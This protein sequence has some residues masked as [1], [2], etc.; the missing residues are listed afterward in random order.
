MF[1][2]IDTNSLISLAASGYG[3]DLFRKMISFQKNK[4]VKLLIS[5]QL[6]HEYKRNVYSLT[7][8]NKKHK[9]ATIE[10][11][12]KNAQATYEVVKKEFGEQV[13][14]SLDSDKALKRFTEVTEKASRKIEKD[15]K[16]VQDKI[17]EMFALG[18][19]MDES[20]NIINR[21]KDRVFR[22][23]PPLPNN[24]NGRITGGDAINWE[25]L[26]EYAVT[27]DLV[28]ITKDGDYGVDADDIHPVLRLEWNEKTDKKLRVHKTLG[29]FVNSLTEKKVIDQK[30]IEKEAALPIPVEGIVRVYPDSY[31][32]ASSYFSKINRD[33]VDISALK[34]AYETIKRT[35]EKNSSAFGFINSK[36][37]SDWQLMTDSLYSSKM[38]L[39]QASNVMK[40]ASSVAAKLSTI[41]DPIKNSPLFNSWIN[42]RTRLTSPKSDGNSKKDD[43]NKKT[44]LDDKESL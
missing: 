15:R 26:L 1:V 31:D 25:F 4:K 12:A 22:G 9:A 7:E 6:I 43:T 3:L 24:D 41:Y 20:P 10:K 29:N 38:S 30:A 16:A 28:L 34:E 11:W 14:K 17:E 36:F 40:E 44:R 21:A 19:R 8:E 37:T 5:K 23:D 27:D 18:I 13:A 39:D 2:F 35:I 42:D 33:Y 32:Y